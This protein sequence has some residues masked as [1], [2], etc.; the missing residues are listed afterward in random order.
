MTRILA[1]MMTQNEAVDLTA[2]VRRLLPYVDSITIVD[3]GSIDSTIITMR[4]WSRR[5]SK[6]R[7]F[8][9]P[10]R[11]NFPEQ[12]NAYLARVAEI[13]QDGD[14]VLAVDPD[15]F[16][17][18][19]SLSRLR[20]V[21][22]QAERSGCL[23]ATIRCRSVS[24]RGGERVHENV[25]DY[26]KRLFYKWH[27]GLRYGHPGV[28]PVHEFLAGAD[29]FMQTDLMYEHVKEENVTWPRGSRNLFCSGGGDNVGAANHRWVELRAIASRLGL[30][31]WHKF[32]AY[33]LKGNVDQELREWAVRYR[34]ETGYA[35][36]SEHREVYKTLYRLYHPEEEPNELRGEHIE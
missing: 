2:N 18:E 12:R 24:T 29:P 5:E 14:W 3:G 11:D 25:D 10:W 19:S 1:A 33:M 7:F 6:I 20:D 13:A 9:N 15:E 4:N 31:T 16:V 30:D 34:H 23:S 35:G 28:M 17:E 32:Q 8:I 27:S 21:A 26:W 22:G 36:A